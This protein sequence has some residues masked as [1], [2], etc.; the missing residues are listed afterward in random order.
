MGFYSILKTR[1]GVF[2]VLV[3][4]NLK[5]FGKFGKN[6]REKRLGKYR[7]CRYSGIGVFRN[8]LSLLFN[9]NAKPFAMGTFASPNT[10]IPTCW[11]LLRWVT[12]IFRVT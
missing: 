2:Y 5:K 1:M 9:C 10:N 4:S 7:M 11:Y 6:G 8:P 3:F 12:Q